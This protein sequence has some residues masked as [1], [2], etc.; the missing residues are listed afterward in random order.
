MVS[1]WLFSA[2]CAGVDAGRVTYSFLAQGGND[3]A[4]VEADAAALAR[5]LGVAAVLPWVTTRKYTT[6]I[7]ED[8]SDGDWPNGA[9]GARGRYQMRVYFGSARRSMVYTSR[10]LIDLPFFGA[11]RQQY[12]APR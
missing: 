5:N 3:D 2:K 8:D 12:V 9:G 6:V 10:I 4:G 11:R 7:N 1:A